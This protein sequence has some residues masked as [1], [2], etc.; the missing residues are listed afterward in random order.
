ML[1]PLLNHVRR[2]HSSDDVCVVH[3]AQA[4]V[5]G[6]CFLARGVAHVA[7]RLWFRRMAAVP[8]AHLVLYLNCECP[9]QV[10]S[11]DRRV[12]LQERNQLIVTSRRVSTII[13]I[14]SGSGRTDMGCLCV[15]ANTYFSRGVLQAPRRNEFPS[16]RLSGVFREVE[17]YAIPVGH[18]D[19]VFVSIF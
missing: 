19:T 9:R 12:C 7:Q 16:R 4:G 11:I 15:A 6:S 2:F 5:F 14:T 3:T 18:F 17:K 13:P 10:V 8:L 1:A